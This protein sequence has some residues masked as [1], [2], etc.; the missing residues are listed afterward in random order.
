[1]KGVP[2]MSLKELMMAYDAV[3]SSPNREAVMQR[4]DE[5]TPKTPRDHAR[6]MN[7]NDIIS[8]ITEI[9][10]AYHCA[11]SL[12]MRARLGQCLGKRGVDVYADAIEDVGYEPDREILKKVYWHAK[13][14]RH[15]EAAGRK[16][17]YSGI[18]IFFH[19]CL[20]EALIKWDNVRSLDEILAG[21][22]KDALPDDYLKEKSEKR[23]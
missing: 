18:R 4:I 23:Y 7:M 20:V 17:G 13:L 5:L 14:D 3:Q 1:M 22:N 21:W 9:T 16:L 19:Q 6:I 11:Q 15:R 12:E 2:E 10:D 8:T